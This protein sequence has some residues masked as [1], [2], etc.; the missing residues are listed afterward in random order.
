MPCCVCVA[1]GLGKS[2]LAK[3]LYNTLLRGTQQFACSTFVEIAVGDGDNTLPHLKAALRALGAAVD[4]AEGRSAL[5]SRLEEYVRHKAVLFVLDNVW[6]L[7]QLKDLLPVEWGE[8]SCVIV[9]SRS[10]EFL[11]M[12]KVSPFSTLVQSVALWCSLA[13]SGCSGSHPHGPH[14]YLKTCYTPG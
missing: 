10:Q 13:V 3:R 8:G 12:D 1:G 7:R 11:G 14:L 6:N 2:T 9:T 4:D 5:C